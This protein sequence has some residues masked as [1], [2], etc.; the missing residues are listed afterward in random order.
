MAYS[1]KQIN[2]K[3]NRILK[4]LS[5]NLGI[6]TPV[7]KKVKVS[8]TTYK[9]WITEDDD[10]KNSIDEIESEQ[11]DFVENVLFENIK[12]G[13]RTSVIFYLKSRGGSRRYVDKQ[14]IEQSVS[15]TEPLKI[16]LIIPDNK[17]KKRLE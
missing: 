13:D 8:Y 4:L 15:Y 6:I 2:S 9:K 12:S 14:V 10:F 5:E 11:F 17:D 3:K 16:N 1:E 7:L